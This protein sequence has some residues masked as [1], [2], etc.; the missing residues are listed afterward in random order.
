MHR[1]SVSNGR[2]KIT[3]AN[4]FGFY[5]FADELLYFNGDSAAAS[6]KVKTSPGGNLSLD[7]KSWNAGRLSWTQS[8]RDM[9]AGRLF[10]EIRNVKPGTYYAILINNK[11]FK[12]IKAGSDAVLSF[13]CKTEK[14]NS[15]IIS[16]HPDI[17][18]D[19]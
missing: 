4:D 15:A 10:Y 3:A 13:N 5:S 17:L 14:N 9:N 16:I 7:I 2:F 11:L 6:L 19:R 1:Y 8:T 18:A 12:T